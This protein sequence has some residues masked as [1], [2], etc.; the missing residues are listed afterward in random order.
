MLKQGFWLFLIGLPKDTEPVI[1]AIKQAVREVEGLE[2]PDEE[3]TLVANREISRVH[4]FSM[5]TI[6]FERGHSLE[7]LNEI[8]T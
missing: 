5:D 8:V 3:S 7:V 4:Y 6:D 1:Q 2:Y